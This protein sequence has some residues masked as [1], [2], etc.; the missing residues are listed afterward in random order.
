MQKGF[1]L[2]PKLRQRQLAMCTQDK[3]LYVLKRCFWLYVVEML[4]Y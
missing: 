3:D 4:L 1:R 2:Q